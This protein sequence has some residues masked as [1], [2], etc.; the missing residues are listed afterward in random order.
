MAPRKGTKKRFPLND[1]LQ[2][3][4]Q[5]DVLLVSAI[6]R[7]REFAKKARKLKRLESKV[8][9]TYMCKIKYQIRLTAHLHVF[10]CYWEN[11]VLNQAH[12]KCVFSS[13]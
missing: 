12:E 4:R 11:L 2:I 7:D 9:S 8:N 1:Y 3:K 5:Q 13:K 10:Q 6:A